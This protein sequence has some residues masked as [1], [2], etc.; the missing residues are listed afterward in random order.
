MMQSCTSR[1][2]C[3][4]APCAGTR[5]TR[6]HGFTR[7]RSHRRSEACVRVLLY[8]G[9]H[10]HA[11]FGSL[12]GRTPLGGDTDRRSRLPYQFSVFGVR[13]NPGFRGAVSTQRM[14]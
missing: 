13:A 6:A 5:T 1:S 14:E 10:T 11:R 7:K 9:Q 4:V 8:R 12:F 2:V 3:R